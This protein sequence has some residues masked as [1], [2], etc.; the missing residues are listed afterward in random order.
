MKK[1]FMLVAVA[2]AAFMISCGSPAD[3]GK[4]YGEQMVEALKS[5]DT[6]KIESLT[7]E[8]DDLMKDYSD[9]EKAEFTKAYLEVVGDEVKSDLGF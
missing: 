7:K 9:E 4:D 3:K 1:I 8:M 6:E 5:E 2:M